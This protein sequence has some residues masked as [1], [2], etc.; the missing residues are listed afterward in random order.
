MNFVCVTCPGWW[1]IRQAVPSGLV[2]GNFSVAVT[3]GVAF[4][5]VQGTK[6]H[7]YT[8]RCS[9]PLFKLHHLSPF[10]HV[11]FTMRAISGLPSSAIDWVL[12]DGEQQSF[13]GFL[14]D[15]AHCHMLVM[16]CTGYGIWLL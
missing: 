10:L 4:L 9:G 15:R 5:L 2:A 8:L 6:A 7:N 14:F 16:P 11:S 3:E 1:P 12:S 13:C